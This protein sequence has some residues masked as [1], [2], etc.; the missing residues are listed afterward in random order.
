MR[1]I[2]ILLFAFLSLSCLNEEYSFN[3]SPDDETIKGITMVAPPDPFPNDPIGPITDVNANWIAVVPYAYSRIGKP[4]VVFN[5]DWQ[6]W[7]E[8]FEGAKES[9]Q[10]AHEKGVKVMLKPQVYIHRSWVG[11]VDF[12]NEA[13]WKKWELDYEKYI[14]EYARLAADEGVAIICVGTEYKIS[15]VK[16]E[17]FWRNLISKVKAIYPGKIIYSANWDSYHNVPIWDAVDYIGISSYFPLTKT[18]TPTLKELQ[19]AWKPIVKKL[20]TFSSM[21][22][23]PILFTEFGYLTVD[24]CADKTW[25]LEKKINALDKN[26]QAQANAIEAL[27]TVFWEEEFWAGGFL[28]KWFPNMQGHEGYPEKDYSPQGKLSEKVIRDWYGLGG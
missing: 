1:R 14:M 21:T 11:E 18:K 27:F 22:K 23:K 6:W 4:D 8:K 25:E 15:V 20:R 9:I 17:K 12:D 2:L 13:E 5:L 26:E 10:L 28:W 19:L 3:I 7:G 16:R 24:Q